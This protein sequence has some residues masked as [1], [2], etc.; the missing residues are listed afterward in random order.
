M[1]KSHRIPR[2]Q[3]ALKQL[4]NLALQQKLRDPALEW[5]NITEVLISKDLRHAKLYFSHYNNPASHDA[6]REQLTKSSGFF[7]KQIA[8]AQIMRTIPELTFFYD[9]TE[10]RAEKVETLLASIKQNYDDDDG[11][12][13]PDINLDDYLDD[14]EVFEV[15]E[16]EEIYKEFLEEEEEEE[17]AGK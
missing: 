8:G 2:L 17:E 4:F 10:D 16:D 1:S 6:I 12:Y 7:K 11:A 5:V 13:D 15:D 3:E 14:D 9:E